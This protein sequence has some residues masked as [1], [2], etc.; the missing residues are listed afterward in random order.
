MNLPEIIYR[1]PVIGDVD[2]SSATL[3]YELAAPLARAYDRVA[4]HELQE[5]IDVHYAGCDPTKL[6]R[7][8]EAAK[9][10]LKRLPAQADVEVALRVLRAQIHT[11]PSVDVR[12]DLVFT[13]LDG[14]NTTATGVYVSN[15]VRKLGNCP[16]RPT[17]ALERLATWFAAAAI[18]AAVDQLLTTRTPKR[19]RP[20]DIADVL[21]VVGKHSSELI[22]LG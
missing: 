22:R 17:E 7:R 18:A 2:L 19:G 11:E 15:L 1:H 3:P 10:L 20:I 16:R 9:P 5:L 6:W 21:D 12:A 8:A 13:M 4:C 14:W